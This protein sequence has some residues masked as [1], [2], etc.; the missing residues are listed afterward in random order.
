MYYSVV[1]NTTGKVYMTGNC[2]SVLKIVRNALNEE[3]NWKGDVN[4]MPFKISKTS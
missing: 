1:S 3:A 2:K 4:N